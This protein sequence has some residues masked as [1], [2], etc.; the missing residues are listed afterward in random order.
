MTKNKNHLNI[1][2]GIIVNNQSVYCFKKGEHRYDYL[3]NRFEFPGGKIEPGENKTDALRREIQEELAVQ[4]HVYEE[5]I[6]YDFEYP[7]FSLTMSCFRCGLKQGYFQLSEHTDVILQ[8]IK[9]LDELDW[10][11]AD[12]RVVKLIMEQAYGEV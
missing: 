5:L 10:L 8:P 6:E 3:S 1:V 2:A 7:D 11:P 4:I 12:V 9:T